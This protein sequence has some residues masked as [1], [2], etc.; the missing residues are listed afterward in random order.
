MTLSLLEIQR[1]FG[2]IHKF[3]VYRYSMP[4]K[5]LPEEFVLRMIKRDYKDFNRLSTAIALITKFGILGY[6]TKVLA[7]SFLPLPAQIL[8]FLGVFYFFKL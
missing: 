5:T 4:A 7:N 6:T 2:L 3:I 1:N 8:V